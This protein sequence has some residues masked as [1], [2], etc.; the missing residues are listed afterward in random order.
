MTGDVHPP[1]DRDRPADEIAD[2]CVHWRRRPTP[3]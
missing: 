2:V 3:G 1:I